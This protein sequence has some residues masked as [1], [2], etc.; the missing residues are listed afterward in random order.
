MSSNA[1]TSSLDVENNSLLDNKIKQNGDNSKKTPSGSISAA[2]LK[3]KFVVGGWS[4]QA[5]CV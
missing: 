2:G 4:R 5:G 3:G 1:T